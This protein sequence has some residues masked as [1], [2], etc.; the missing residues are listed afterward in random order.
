L[1]TLPVTGARLATAAAAS[2]PG[3][4]VVESPT[5]QAA[6]ETL[7]ARRDRFDTVILSPGAPSYGQLEQ[8]GVAFSSFEERGRA[9]VQI[10]EALFR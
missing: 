8:P 5:L 2:A 10:A 1:V 6:M 7:S 9:F 4:D 3:V